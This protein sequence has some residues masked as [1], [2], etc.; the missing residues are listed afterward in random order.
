MSASSIVSELTVVIVPETVRFPV[1]ATLPEKSPSTPSNDN[2]PPEAIV[3]IFPS[4]YVLFAASEPSTGAESSL[5]RFEFI[6][7]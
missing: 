7:R 2:V 4:T 3:E 5:M 6:S 1:T